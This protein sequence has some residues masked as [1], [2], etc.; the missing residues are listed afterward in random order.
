M[1]FL[2]CKFADAF[3]ILLI[4][5]N[6]N[7]GD[8][9]DY[10]AVHPKDWLSSSR[11]ACCKKFFGGYLYK[12]CMGLY[13]PNQDNCNEMLFYPDWNGSNKGCLADAQEPYYMLINAEYYLS[14]TREECCEKFYEWDYYACTGTTP[15]LKHG[16]YYPDWSGSS[17][18]CS[19]N[20]DE[21]PPYMIN[22]QAWY[23]SSSLKDCCERHFYWNRN[24]CL[25]TE[26]VGSGEW[27][28]K[29]DANTCVQDCDGASPCGG[30]AAGWDETFSDKKQC[31]QNKLWWNR[32]CLSNSG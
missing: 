12:H 13:P 15:E 19:N 25:G 23:F 2:K 24:E 17:S 10:M 31:C 5:S 3:S 21:I 29:Y 14:E 4:N 11:E 8:E 26:A 30:L 28:V 27:Y 32:R 1:L 6:R 9:P 20:V 16:E 22:N 18:S 7:D